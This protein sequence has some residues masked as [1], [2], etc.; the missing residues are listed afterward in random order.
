MVFIVLII[1]MI[2]MTL[3]SWGIIDVLGWSK[4]II[5][6]LATANA[7]GTGVLA[8]TLAATYLSTK[9]TWIS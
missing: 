3:V 6:Q 8:T 1:G 7:V 4:R 2:I 9:S 5:Y